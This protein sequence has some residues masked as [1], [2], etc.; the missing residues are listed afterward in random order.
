M[1]NSDS[2]G[3][4]SVNNIVDYNT[5]TRTWTPLGSGTN[6][7]VDQYG[8]NAMTYFS[9]KL[10]VGG[11]F[12][13]AGGAAAS[14]IAEWDGSS[15]EAL[16]SGVDNTVYSLTISGGSLYV[17]GEFLNAGGSPAKYI[18]KWDG[19]NW[20]YV[21]TTP[22]DLNGNITAIAPGGNSVYIGGIFTQAG[23]TTVNKIAKW[24]GTSWSAVG[25]GVAG[26]Q[27]EVWSLIWFGNTLYACG[28][29]ATAGLLTV[30]NVVEIDTLTNTYSA[31]GSGTT[32]GTN[33]EIQNGT[34]ANGKL[35]LPGFFTAAGGV[36]AIGV[37]SWDGT[38]WSSL[39]G[40]TN[41]PGGYTVN[42]LALSGS[43]IYVGGDFL[44]A[45][46]VPANY[47]AVFNTSTSTWSSLGT[48][49]TNG[50]DNGVDA[51]A[52]L[53][54][55]IY[56][57]GYFTNA[58][59][60]PAD[61]IAMW[62]GTKWNT[63]GTTPNDGVDGDV[64][65]LALFGSK[66]YVGGKFTHAGGSPASYA[67]EW[68]G[69]AWSTIGTGVDSNVYAI[70]PGTG[71]VY[72]G[73]NFTH[74]GGSSANYIAS[75]NGATWSALG[76]PTNG[77]DRI[78]YA[79]AAYGDTLFAGG[80]FLH[81]GGSPANYL[82]KWNTHDWTVLGVGVNAEVST[83]ARNGED[84]FIGGYFSASG[85]VNANKVIMWSI[86]DS[87][88]STLGDGMNDMVDAAV[89]TG[90]D[91]YFGGDFSTAG[92]KPS[93]NFARYNPN[94][95]VA[96]KEKPPV[97]SS[98]QLLQN[99]PNPFNPTTTISYELSANSFVTLKVY[100]ILGREVA[101][102][103]NETQSPGEYSVKFDGSRFASGVYFYRMSAGNY[104]SI[105]KAALVK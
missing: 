91:T 92:G 96:V 83:L 40:S 65:A 52:V 70:A 97:A 41:A 57:G 27:S 28:Y 21:G 74:A 63:L 10:Y 5:S 14:R 30:N 26:Y 54:T 7:G 1:E 11:Y 69:T 45:G 36:V 23:G 43:N 67:A 38:N 42:A 53:G 24:N 102:L 79:L 31:L 95:I 86:A 77:V 90:E 44:T 3:G 89:S 103:V 39:G 15:W 73:G 56:A 61:H 2:A 78:V 4:V 35:Y 66:L 100:D 34:A 37:A 94:G 99:Y 46:T 13:H 98:F 88:F 33:N 64:F 71:E 16:G 72:F 18:A 50:V 104:T 87:A 17:V 55:D 25:P 105:K 101:T 76:A 47:I 19:M 85:L 29:F 68:N 82:A 81:A 9:G 12:T 58:G 60:N 59:G 48:G 22:T 8:V 62:D 93:Y 20:S 51:I 6:N 32:V 49:T 80:A 75:W 84:L